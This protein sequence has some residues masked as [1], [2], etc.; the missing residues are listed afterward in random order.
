MDEIISF[1]SNYFILNYIELDYSI[2]IFNSYF[3]FINIKLFLNINK[4]FKKFLYII[5]KI[6]FLLFYKLIL[7]FFIKI[8]KNAYIYIKNYFNYIFFII[9]IIFIFFFKYYK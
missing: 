2:T 7:F 1:H 6:L 8:F 5:I 4:I 3:N 9:I